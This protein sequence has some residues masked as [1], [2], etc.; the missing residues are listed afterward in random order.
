MCGYQHISIP[1]LAATRVEEMLQIACFADIYRHAA[2]A[3]G[4]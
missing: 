2:V 1:S 3:V 4:N